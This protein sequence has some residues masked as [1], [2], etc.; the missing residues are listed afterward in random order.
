MFLW[1]SLDENSR[2][3]KGAT[4]ERFERYTYDRDHGDLLK[5]ETF[6][7]NDARLRT[8]SYEYD[9]RTGW[10]LGVNTP[11]GRI[12]YDTITGRIRNHEQADALLHRTYRQGW[13]I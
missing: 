8:V 13:S 5:V 2:L 9:P 6:D 1:E 11:E 4:L 12:E 3:F 7:G 10:L